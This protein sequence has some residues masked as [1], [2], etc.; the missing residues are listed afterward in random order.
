MYN[1]NDQQSAGNYIAEVYERYHVMI[2]RICYMLMKNTADTEDAV[3]NTF[4]NMIKNRKRFNDAE[5]EKAWLIRTAVNI[6]KNDLKHWRRKNKN[7][8]NYN[9][10]SQITEDYDSLSI[11]SD[12][13]ANLSDKSQMYDETLDAV[14]RLP[15][16][17]KAV[18]Y[19]YYYEGYKSAEIAQM[20]HKPQSTVRNHLSEARLILR[21]S[22]GGD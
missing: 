13:T 16:K 9:L 20:L 8:D 17:Y 18:I 1:E 11:N 22:I 10:S 14:L 21:N 2:Y 15:Q 3:Q 12:M 4:I 19:L 6:C 5:H 7:L